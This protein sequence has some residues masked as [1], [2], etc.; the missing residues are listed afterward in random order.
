MYTIKYFAE[1]QH[2]R[3]IYDIIISFDPD[4]L[5]LTLKAKSPPMVFLDKYPIYKPETADFFSVLCSNVPDINHQIF[6]SNSFGLRRKNGQREYIDM[7]RAIPDA[8]EK[9][10]PPNP[11]KYSLFW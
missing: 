9:D 6:W 10:M 3:L 1:P 8:K 7:V 11:D 2:L 5:E 4:L